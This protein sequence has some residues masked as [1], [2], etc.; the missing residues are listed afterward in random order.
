MEYTEERS[1]SQAPL[2]IRS[3]WKKAVGGELSGIK[4][5]KILLSLFISIAMAILIYGLVAASIKS[6]IAG[7]ALSAFFLA[8]LIREGFKS[9]RELLNYRAVREIVFNDDEM[10]VKTAGEKVLR[11]RYNEIGL[12]INR[13][14]IQDRYGKILYIIPFIVVVYYDFDLRRCLDLWM[15]KEAGNRVISEYK[16]YI[17]RTE[18]SPCPSLTGNVYNSDY[19][20]R[21]IEKMKLSAFC[22]RWYR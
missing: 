3:N 11:V 19:I 16:K 6:I 5:G 20:Y 18:I 1:G 4:W 12:I 17:T 9:E 10:L 22:Q 2:T 21:P 15:D 8:L 7:I 13:E 14:A